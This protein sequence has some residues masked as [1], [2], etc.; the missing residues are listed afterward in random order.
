MAR[1]PFLLAGVWALI[2]IGGCSRRGPA[3]QPS[4]GPA[5]HAAKPRPPKSNPQTHVVRKTPVKPVKPKRPANPRLTV[6][7]EVGII[8]GRV[9]WQGAADPL[10]GAG[11]GKA[12]SQTVAVDGKQVPIKLNQRLCIHPNNQGIANVVV[13]LENAPDGGAV[14][15]GE[16]AELRQRDGD[17]HPH[18][19]TARLGTRL[20][21][22]SADDRAD[23]QAGGAQSF[24]LALTRGKQELRLLSR[25][26]LVEVRS[27]ALPSLAYVW[28]FRHRHYAQTDA[29]GRFRLPAVPPGKYE[30]VLWHE[31]WRGSDSSSPAVRK[32]VT[33]TL[34]EREGKSVEWTLSRKK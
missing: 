19:L 16:D 23:F 5:P 4:K 15:A 7:E 2:V 34:G 31:G 6:T 18:V 9:R 25:P 32:Q 10:A 33:L 3:P 30:L 11:A 13:W 24:S 1:W 28:V 8:Q 29:D 14:E 21:L 20:K 26:G 22:V 27:D 17:F 12:A